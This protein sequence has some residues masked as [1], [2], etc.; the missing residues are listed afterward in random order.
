MPHLHA[1]ENTFVYVYTN[2]EDNIVGKQL[3][4]QLTSI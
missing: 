2:K 3:A 4:L 1:T